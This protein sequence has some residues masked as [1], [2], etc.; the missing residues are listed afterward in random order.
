M[1][2]SNVEIVFNDLTDSLNELKKSKDSPRKVRKNFTDFVNYSIKL[3][4]IMRKEY[5][6]ITGEL[7]CAENFPYWNDISELFKELRNTDQ[8]QIP[9]RVKIRDTFSFSTDRIFLTSGEK[10]SDIVFEGDWDISNPSSDDLP[11][12]VTLFIGEPDDPSTKIIEAD[13]R[14]INYCL[15][16][17]TKEI[18]DILKKID[19]D[20]IFYL[21]DAYYQILTRYFEF[22]KTEVESNKIQ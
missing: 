12:P 19:N 4:S 7:W 1:N 5:K 18:E 14:T 8:H 10:G 6:Q 20:E 13:R 11:K 9:I 21:S 17:S 2:V 15:F 3:T 22:Y 16:A